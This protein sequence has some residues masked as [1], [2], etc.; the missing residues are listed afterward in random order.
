MALSRDTFE[1]LLKILILD[2][3]RERERERVCVKRHES[4]RDGK[5]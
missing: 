2:R 3:E 1:L 4:R 5:K